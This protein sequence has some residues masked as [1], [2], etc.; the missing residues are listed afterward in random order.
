VAGVERGEFD[1]EMAG[2]SAIVVD[3]LWAVV[4]GRAVC[5]GRDW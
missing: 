1:S 4:R 3:V 5:V 2:L